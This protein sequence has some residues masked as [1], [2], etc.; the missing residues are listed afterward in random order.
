[1]PHNVHG[2]KHEQKPGTGDPINPQIEKPISVGFGTRIVARFASVG[3][4][5]PLPE[6]HS[7]IGRAA[8][9]VQP[10]AAVDTHT[11]K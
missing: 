4:E 5:V 8:R 6:L 3:L 11:A 7:E 9:T 10:F 1:M 2:M